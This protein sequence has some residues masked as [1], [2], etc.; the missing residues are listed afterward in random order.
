MQ[1][2]LTPG[3]HRE[4]IFPLPPAELR[5]GVPAFVGLVRDRR[6]EAF[7]RDVSLWEPSIAGRAILGEVDEDKDADKPRRFVRWAEFEGTFLALRHKSYL[8]HAVRGFFENGGRLCYVQVVDVDAGASV[9]A[10][11]AA[12]ALE[13]GLKALEVLEDVDLVCAPDIMWPHQEGKRLPEDEVLRMQSA[14]LKHCRAR[15]D[16]FAILD[17][18]P[19]ADVEQ[20]KAYPEKLRQT[21]GLDG[22]DGALY[23]PWIGVLD[24]PVSNGGFVPPCGHVAG[25]YARTDERIGVHKAPANEVLEGAVDLRVNLTDAQQG[26]LNPVGVNCIRA[27]PGRGI[28]VWG[29]RTLSDPDQRAWLYVNVR[30]LFLTAARW[31]ERNMADVV[32]EP[33]DANLWEQ[34]K[35]DLY[36]YFNGLFQRG[37]LKGSTPQEAFYVKCD[38]EINPPEVRDLGHVVTEIGLAPALP[39]EFIVVRLIHSASGVTIT[40]PTRPGQTGIG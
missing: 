34:I 1:S 21:G 24:G 35:R 3:V 2:Y 29:A 5:T 4:D 30:R 33:H 14:V 18:P 40:G 31:I 27:F 20:A 25:V 6:D 38:A 10:S 37:A 36:V 23:Y 17:A 11:S 32:F 26:R 8:P 13:K 16:R 15:G 7:L 28:R 12:T 39:N 22:I 9:A 19:F